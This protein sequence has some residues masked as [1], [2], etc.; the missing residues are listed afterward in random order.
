MS[1]IILTPTAHVA[2]QAANLQSNLKSLNRPSL[3]EPQ[4]PREP[5]A[6]LISFPP[7]VE[8]KRHDFSNPCCIAQLSTATLPSSTDLM[9]PPKFHD[10]HEQPTSTSVQL[11]H[12]EGITALPRL[13]GALALTRMR[14]AHAA[15]P[16]TS[17]LGRFPAVKIRSGRGD[18][19]Q[20]RPDALGQISAQ[21]GGKCEAATWVRRTSNEE[22]I[23]PGSV[24]GYAT[25]TWKVGPSDFPRN[26]PVTAEH[27]APR[28]GHRSPARTRR[29]SACHVTTHAA[30]D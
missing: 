18:L 12:T 30:G 6:P 4:C 19:G 29:P 26:P 3:L 15:E 17:D 27:E 21:V 9:R 16:T 23:E 28:R 22:Y 5:H 25:V 13:F 2:S 1:N 24:Q 10:L 8:L 7:H 11:V 14:W 20:G